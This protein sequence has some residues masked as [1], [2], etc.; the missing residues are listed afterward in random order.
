MNETQQKIY[1]LLKRKAYSRFELANIIGVSEK[2]IRNYI[3]ELQREIDEDIISMPQESGTVKYFL[4]NTIVD[5][6]FPNKKKTFSFID[7]NSPNPFMFIRI[8]DDICGFDHDRELEKIDIIPVADLHYGHVYSN[9]KYFQDWINWIA[10]NDHVFPFCIGDLMEQATKLSISDGIYYQNLT[11]QEQIFKSAEFLYPIA[12]KILFMTRGNHEKR[13]TAVGLD[14]MEMVA[15]LIHCVYK[16]MTCQMVIQ[17]REHNW[18][19][20]CFHGNTSS[21]T[22][23]G[24]M[25]A[26]LRPRTFNDFRHFLV[27]AHVHDKTVKEYMVEVNDLEKMET[28]LLKAYLIITGSFLNYYGTYAHEKN[29]APGVP[30]CVKLSL[31]EDGDV[32]ISL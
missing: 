23:G 4:A 1:E 15:K 31:Y 16:R 32:H 18:S 13:Q 9:V 7:A 3:P 24:K 10:K 17:W 12:D 29:Y 19:F 20:Y 2:T 26:A 11:P 21:R 22:E 5:K 28:K 6:T 25:N 30:G 8:P 14:V 27:S